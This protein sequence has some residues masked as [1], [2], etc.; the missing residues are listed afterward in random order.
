MRRDEYGNR[1][2]LRLKPF[3][4]DTSNNITYMLVKS[5]PGSLLSV[6]NG[7]NAFFVYTDDPNLTISVATKL[8]SVP[9]KY[10]LFGWMREVKI[11]TYI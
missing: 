1:W 7:A 5:N 2:E 10:F 9:L 6:Y 3:Y 4:T 8:S 11:M